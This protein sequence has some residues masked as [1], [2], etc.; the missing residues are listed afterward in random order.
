MTNLP[1]EQS[2]RGETI[3]EAPEY[4][5]FVDKPALLERSR[6]QIKARFPDSDLSKIPLGIGTRKGLVDKVVALGKRGGEVS[7]FREDGK[8]TKA[9]EDQ[10]GAFLG[11]PAENYHS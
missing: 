6:E 7:I 2:G 11:S 3:P 10:F 8:I 4:T 1:Q 9:F 5:D